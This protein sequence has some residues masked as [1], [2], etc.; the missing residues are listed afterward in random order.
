MEKTKHQQNLVFFVENQKE[1][2]NKFPNKYL[3]IRNQEIAFVSDD[4]D[5]AF[6]K[7]FVLA[8]RTK[9]DFLDYCIEYS[10]PLYKEIILH[11]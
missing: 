10:D 8:Y 7:G 5:E 1:I 4:F 11:E 6:V 3:V 2:Q 9:E